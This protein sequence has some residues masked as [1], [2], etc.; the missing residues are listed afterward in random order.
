VQ[1][2]FQVTVRTIGQ[3]ADI[4][5]DAVRDGRPA[6]LESPTATVI[7]PAGR[8]MTVPMLQ[9]APGRYSASVSG[10]APGAY[11]VT[12]NSDPADEGSTTRKETAGFTLR[13]NAEMAAFGADEHTLRRIASET[14]GHVLSRPADAFRWDEQ[15]ST[16][17]SDPLW[18]IIALCGLLLFLAQVAARRLGI[19][20]RAAVRRLLG[21]AT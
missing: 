5:L 12:V 11:E 20:P 7:D 13:D 14:G 18:Q 10:T 3:Q 17:R 9:L 1:R 4:M 6:D 16:Q 19:S 8:G 21:R 2:D 15:P